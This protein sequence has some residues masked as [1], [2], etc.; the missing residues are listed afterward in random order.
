MRCIHSGSYHA[1]QLG[2]T[3]KVKDAVSRNFLLSLLVFLET[4][5][6]EIGPSDAIDNDAASAAYVENF[7]LRIFGMADNEDR[8]GKATKGT[9]KKFLAAVNFLELLKVFDNTEISESVSCAHYASEFSQFWTGF[10]DRR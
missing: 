9:A 7:A 5:K 3:A 4:L 2:I 8:S 10:A 1:A 6:Q